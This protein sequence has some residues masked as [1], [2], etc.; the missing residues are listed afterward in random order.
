MQREWSSQAAMKKEQCSSS[1]RFWPG[2]ASLAGLLVLWSFP[3]LPMTIVKSFDGRK[4]GL[5]ME[6]TGISR[7]V[8]NGKVS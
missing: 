5:V 4:V 7:W 2:G 3:G 6:I 8:K 1:Q